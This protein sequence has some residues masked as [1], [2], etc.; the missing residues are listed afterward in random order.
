MY[1][2]AIFL[3]FGSISEMV[4]QGLVDDGKSIAII[5]RMKTQIYSKHPLIV[6]KSLIFDWNEA[7][8]RNIQS[9]KAFVIWRNCDFMS[10]D[11]FQDSK[12]RSWLF[13]DQF[14]TLELVHLSSASVYEDSKMIRSESSPILYDSPKRKV[15]ILLS[16]LV[17]S[18]ECA[19]TNLRIS[20]I[21]GDSIKSGFIF[22]CLQAIEKEKYLMVFQSPDIERD[23]LHVGDLVQAILNLPSQ[24]HSERVINVSTGI[25]TKVSKVLEIISN[26]SK[27]KPLLQ[28]VRAPENIQESSILSCEKLKGLIQWSPKPLNEGL[29]SLILRSE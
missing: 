8:V 11:N 21:Y 25:G 18:K 22:D 23:Y 1:F 2:D 20:N 9:R 28:T 17:R 4:A 5:T 3:G 13:S 16:Q 26:L 12:M 19:V 24:M 7:T 15:E 6:D 27:S 14:Q 10:S 29:Y